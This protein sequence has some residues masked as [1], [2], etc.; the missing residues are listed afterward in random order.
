MFFYEKMILRNNI[1][2]QIKHRKYYLRKKQLNRKLKIREK[3]EEE[4]DEK[5]K[6]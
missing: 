4:I 6:R 3:M 1:I 2:L 5:N